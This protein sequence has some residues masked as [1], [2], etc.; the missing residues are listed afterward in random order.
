M[1]EVL[2]TEVCT[3]AFETKCASIDLK[4]KVI[5]IKDQCHNITHTVC[6]AADEV[7]ENKICVYSYERQL[8]EMVAKTVKVTYNKECSSQKV[9]VC[10]PVQ[11]HSYQ[12]YGQQYCKEEDQETCYNIP[13]VTPVDTKVSVIF[14]SP[15]K[16]CENKPIS[17][18]RISCEDLIEEKCI[19]VPQ[20]EE[21]TE[22]VEKCKV[23]L[24]KQSCQEISLTLPK[25][26]CVG[27]V[28]GHAVDL[29]A[30]EYHAKV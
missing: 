10:Q 24:A 14:P 29:T 19:K 3:P 2:K 4:V 7:I 12:S 26:V 9:S 25:Q 16:T 21:K 8:E 11:S 20:I 1:D 22:K 27:L 13:T 5:I 28:H 23:T 30:S 15:L 18:T 17:I 6:S